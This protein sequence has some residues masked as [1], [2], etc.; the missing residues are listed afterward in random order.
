MS[1]ATAGN[2]QPITVTDGA[3]PLLL[4]IGVAGKGWQGPVMPFRFRALARRDVEAAG[5]YYAREA[6][7]AVSSGFYIA[8]EHVAVGVIQDSQFESFVI[9]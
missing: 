1:Q 3:K 2:L 5:A 4:D 8:L 9:R 7:G 6:G